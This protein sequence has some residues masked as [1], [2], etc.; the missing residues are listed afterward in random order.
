MTA[1]QKIEEAKFFLDHM[2]FYQPDIS[3]VKF[4]FSAY[5][6]AVQSIPDYVLHEA[7]LIFELRLP[8]NETWYP[9]NY[10]E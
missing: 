9:K 1:N 7:N 2:K 10:K 5:L 8:E 6:G 3:I 4:Y